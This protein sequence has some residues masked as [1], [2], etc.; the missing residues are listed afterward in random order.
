MFFDLLFY[1]F[2][3]LGAM[4][5]MR[6]L[7]KQLPGVILFNATNESVLIPSSKRAERVC[8]RHCEGLYSKKYYFPTAYFVPHEKV[9]EIYEKITH[10][11]NDGQ[12]ISTLLELHCTKESN[13]AAF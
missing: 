9:H 2:V 1:P 13:E 5:K 8:K 11:Q 10:D 6:Q 7:K 3:T 12:I 4:K